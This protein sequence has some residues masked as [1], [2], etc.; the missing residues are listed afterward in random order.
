[1]AVLPN[2]GYKMQ[3]STGNSE[4]QNIIQTLHFKTKPTSFPEGDTKKKRKVLIRTVRQ[5]RGRNGT[6]RGKKLPHKDCGCNCSDLK[7][8]KILSVINRIIQE[9]FGACS[10]DM[11][12]QPQ[13]CY[14]FIMLSV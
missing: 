10:L 6:T 11:S 7:S 1:M 14:N 8:D 3:D 9:T 12:V 2:V 5:H 13:E 4:I